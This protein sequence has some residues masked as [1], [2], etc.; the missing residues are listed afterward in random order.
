[1]S[2]AAKGLKAI[3]GSPDRV[4]DRVGA[5]GISAPRLGLRFDTHGTV[6]SEEKNGRWGIGNRG[7]ARERGEGAA[8]MLSENHVEVT[9]PPDPQVGSYDIRTL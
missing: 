9:C 6:V 8:S 4:P 3:V 7:S 1:M 2:V 5:G